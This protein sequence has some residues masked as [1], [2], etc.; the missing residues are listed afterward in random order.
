VVDH[1]VGEARTVEM[2]HMLRIS[3]KA[4][5]DQG[6]GWSCGLQRWRGG[7]WDWQI[8]G[9]SLTGKVLSPSTLHI[10]MITS[11]MRLAWGNPFGLRLR[12]VDEK[13]DNLFIAKFGCLADKQKVLEG[14]PWVV[15]WYV[16]IL[17]DYNEWLKPSDVSF[18]R[19]LMW[20]HILD[21]PFGWTNANRGSHAAGLIGDVLKIDTDV[22]GKA[23]GAFICARV[24]V[25]MSKPL[26]RGIMLKKDK[27][28]LP[29]EWFAI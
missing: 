28:S 24:M 27:S 6:W 13:A 12:S 19:V 18:I 14:S 5:P 4:K 25:D 17:Q 22:E 26:R 15:G 11:A 16:V 9:V 20:V 23:Y 1:V 3:W 29:P 2:M 10:S 8:S 21:L 7:W